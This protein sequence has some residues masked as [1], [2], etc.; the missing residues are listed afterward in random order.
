ME[1]ALAQIQM[2][3]PIPQPTRTPSQKLA[4]RRKLL[5]IHLIEL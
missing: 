3:T 1:T 4:M 2:V 5:S